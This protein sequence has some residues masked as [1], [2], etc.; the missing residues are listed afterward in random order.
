MIFSTKL[1]VA[2]LG[3]SHFSGVAGSKQE[4]EELRR[5]LRQ[6]ER[7]TQCKYHA[8][9]RQTSTYL[10]KQ[11]GT[12]NSLC[13]VFVHPTMQTVMFT[14]TDDQISYDDYFA[15][16]PEEIG[17]VA[18]LNQVDDFFKDSETGT[19]FDWDAAG[20][21]EEDGRAYESSSGDYTGKASKI[22]KMLWDETP[23]TS[24]QAKGSK[25]MKGSKGGLFTKAS[26]SS[27]PATKAGKSGSTGRVNSAPSS[28]YESHSGGYVVEEA[29]GDGWLAAFSSGETMGYSDLFGTTE[30][31][32]QRSGSSGHVTSSQFKANGGS[33]LMTGR[34]EGQEAPTGRK[35]FR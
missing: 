10:M 24:K 15:P 33:N 18:D 9:N 13:H 31:M 3:V 19:V 28:D 30:E 23:V 14:A 12:C 2:T 6:G 21:T 20:V 1:L 16:G 26:S 29:S 35:F 25:T 4:R 8:L 34:M 5:N 7:R 32:Q 11:I 17:Q 27:E 22:G